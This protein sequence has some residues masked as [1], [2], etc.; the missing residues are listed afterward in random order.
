MNAYLRLK[1]QELAQTVKDA[2]GQ[3]V[4]LNQQGDQH[5]QTDIMM[6]MGVHVHEMEENGIEG[7][8]DHKNCSHFSAT[9]GNIV[10]V[11][12]MLR[13]LCG[14]HAQIRQIVIDLAAEL[15]QQ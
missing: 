1:Q 13:S 7:V 11:S 3:L 12:A 4:V 5:H 15:N 2:I 10:G 14:R 6:V 8:V 9:G